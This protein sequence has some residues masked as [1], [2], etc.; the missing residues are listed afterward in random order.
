[1]NV[2]VTG[3]SSPLGE[4][5]LP[6]LCRDHEVRALARSQAAAKRVRSRGAE[7]VDGDIERPG[8]WEHAASAADAVVHLAGVK[9]ADPVVRIVRPA[10][11]LTIISSAS[12]RNPAHPL[13]KEL[14]EHEKRLAGANAKGLVILRPTMIYGSSVDRNVRQLVKLVRRLPVVPRFV[15]GGFVQPVFADDVADAI[16]T[17]MLEQRHL[18]ADLGGPEPIRFGDVVSEIA[19]L[20]GRKVRPLPVPMRATARAAEL[21][22]GRKPSRG[23]HALAMLR[24]DRTV[25][26]PGVEI[27]GRQ[28]TPFAEGLAIAMSRYD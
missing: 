8:D 11:T 9:R 23:M 15:G 12:M 22:G 1:M 20:L 13:S 16:A 6:R 2:F 5:V 18:E 21:L 19:R 24:H 7:P 25:D 10:Q 17:T 27:L 26:P 28:G 14:I 3:G 4:R